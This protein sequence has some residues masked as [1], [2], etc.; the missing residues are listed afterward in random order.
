MKSSSSELAGWRGGI[1]IT[2]CSPAKL[3][4]DVLEIGYEILWDVEKSPIVAE[5]GGIT[6]FRYWSGIIESDL[7]NKTYGYDFTDMEDKQKAAELAYDAYAEHTYGVKGLSKYVTVKHLP[8]GVYGDV[9]GSMDL[10]GDNP[11]VK[12]VLDYNV[13]WFKKKGL[14]RGGIAIDNAGKI[15]ESFLIKLRTKLNAEGLGLATNG[16]PDELLK[17][18]DFYGKEGFRFTVE[19]ARKVRKAGFNG[20]L[21]EFHRQ[22]LSAKE[23][24]LYMATRHFHGILFFGYTNGGI[25]R[26]AEHSFYATRPDVYDHQRWVFRK[27]VPLS[28]ALHSAGK[29]DEPYAILSGIGK[30]DNDSDFSF[31]TSSDINEEGKVY[32]YKG[33][34][35]VDVIEMVQSSTGGRFIDRYGKSAKDGGVYFYINSMTPE[36][37]VCDI[38]KLDIGDDVIAFDEFNRKILDKS[39]D[40]TGFKFK[41]QDGP[42]L[43]QVGSPQTVAKN[44]FKRVE[45][46]LEQQLVQH[47]MEQEMGY[48]SSLKPWAGFCRG[49]TLDTSEKRSGTQSLVAVGKTTQKAR[50]LYYERR[51]AAQFVDLHQKTPQTIRLSAH[52]KCEGVTRV[53]PEELKTVQQRREHFDTVDGYRYCAH[54]YI[55]YQ[56]GEW[57][58]VHTINFSPGTHDWEEVKIEVTPDKPVATAMVLLEFHQPEGKVW[59]D[60]ISLKTPGRTFSHV[61]ALSTMKV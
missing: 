5:M 61:P 26:G 59:F 29:S 11:L 37:V 49:Y 7:K 51:G 3:I 22:H 58:E 39:Q 1:G 47:R 52:S 53:D 30:V 9:Y 35:F 60:D 33:P 24:S 42:A 43:I 36:T 54:L 40:E 6:Q 18:V 34:G 28:R 46:M 38:D 16:C 31:D 21:G 10:D 41:T 19:Y 25:A 2:F 48:S 44:I 23:L 14:T 55:D 15:P 56:D 8:D 13:N 4:P 12:A 50:W 45:N 27:Y 17:Y 57:P 32:E 20:I